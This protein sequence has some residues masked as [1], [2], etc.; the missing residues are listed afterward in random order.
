LKSR[1][2][3]AAFFFGKSFI[4]NYENA[5]S[6]NHGGFWVYRIGIIKTIN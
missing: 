1:L 5:K 2:I 3:T 4:I 6:I